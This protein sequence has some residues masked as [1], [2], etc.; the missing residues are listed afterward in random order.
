[1]NSHKRAQMHTD[2]SSEMDGMSSSKDFKR[3]RAKIAV[4]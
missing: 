3:S 4:G 1:M 2:N